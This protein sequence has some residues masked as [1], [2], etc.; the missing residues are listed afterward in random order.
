MDEILESFYKGNLKFIKVDCGEVEPYYIIS[1]GDFRL[2]MNDK[3]KAV[4]K[5]FRILEAIHD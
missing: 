4:D 3:Q 2:S 5:F 1:I